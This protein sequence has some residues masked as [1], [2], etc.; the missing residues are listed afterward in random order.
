[1]DELTRFARRLI[2]QLAASKDGV[3]RA[4]PIGMVRDKILPYRTHRRALMLES[5]EDY[6]TVLL[7]LVAGERGF[8]R[9]L[10]V[11]AAQRCQEELADANPD[12]GVLDE[13]A[14]STIQIT[15]LAAAQILG[16]EADG[17]APSEAKG[18][19]RDV[20][21]R[22]AKGP[23]STETP[24]PSAE[25]RPPGDNRVEA[26]ARI[27]KERPAASVASLPQP[28]HSTEEPVTMTECPHC[29]HAMPP[30]REVVF[31]PWCGKR[32]IPFTCSRCQT[33]LDSDWRHCI[34][35]GAPVKDPY[36]FT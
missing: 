8:V 34:T 9:T 32:L 2:E 21:L 31:C 14:E 33:E 35:C 10:P 17:V 20:T 3:N 12:L 24:A 13:V 19:E 22:E 7:R 29:H 16:D 27:P 11:A 26:K 6:E 1:M 30:G 15:S 23:I 28:D 18:R 4:V 25:T 5:V 36:R